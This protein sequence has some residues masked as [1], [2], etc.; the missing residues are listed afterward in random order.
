M[1][2]PQKPSWFG[3]A[4]TVPESGTSTQPCHGTR[5]IL[6][7]RAT[8]IL[9]V[10]L[11]L[12]ACSTG[13]HFAPDRQ[14]IDSYRMAAWQVPRAAGL[15]SVLVQP[16]EPDATA[17][18]LS[19][20]GPI[21]ADPRPVIVFLPGLG[22]GAES[23]NR[24]TDAW[25]M[26]GFL[27]IACQ[28]WETD[29]RIWTSDLARS[30]DF[31]RVAATR[32][33]ADTMPERLSRLGTALRRL[34]HRPLAPGYTGPVPDWD[35]VA[36]AGDDLGAYT[37]QSFLLKAPARRLE[38]AAGMRFRAYLAISPVER[39]TYVAEAPVAAVDAPVL[40]ISSLDDR[41]P[42]GIVQRIDLRHKA[43]DGLSS[44]NDYYLEL[45]AADHHWLAGLPTAESPEALPPQR[46][47]LRDDAQG[48]RRGKGRKEGA[49]PEFE[50]DDPLGD[51]DKSKA[52]NRAEREAEMIRARNAQL[53]RQG[54]AQASVEL[55]SAA[56]LAAYL[57]SDNEARNW[58]DAGAAAWLR[59]GDQLKHRSRAAH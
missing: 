38:L 15:A 17:Y 54:E 25:A 58:L 4:R 40:M 34:R 20:A 7:Q 6:R 53:T 35:R 30:G 21:G 56:F 42:Y 10:L 23:A 47:P 13:P 52:V 1:P 3:P 33:S 2:V 9:S 37:L 51:A 57:R 46:A 50:D 36:L 24:W 8:A 55:V 59:N 32:F 29:A 49:A 41:D 16:D 31:A 19:W 22:L 28:P 48:N 44:G 11:G 5:A 26:A 12:C 27:V 18:R 45:N 14:A 43:F 39:E